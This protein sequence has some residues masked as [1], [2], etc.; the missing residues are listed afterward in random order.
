MDNR[1]L[2]QLAGDL[3]ADRDDNAVDGAIARLT[4]ATIATRDILFIGAPTG[5]AQATRDMIV[6]KFGRTT[7]YRGGRITSIVFD[8]LVPYEDRFDLF[9][10]FSEF[11]HLALEHGVSS[12][13]LGL[14]RH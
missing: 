2:L 11:R 6:H 3:R 12:H 4:P 10:F 7:T 8:V 9:E 14:M 1:R 5:T 13:Q